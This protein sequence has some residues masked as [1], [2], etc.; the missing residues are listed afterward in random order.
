MMLKLQPF[1][2]T[3]KHVPGKYL[4]I[5]DTL[6]RDF[7]MASCDNQM[8]F[9]E[10]LE[11]QVAMLIENLPVTVENWKLISK[12]SSEDFLLTKLKQYILKGWPTNYKD[13]DEILRPFFEFKDELVVIKELIFR[14]DRILIPVALKKYMLNKLHTGHPGINRMVKKAELT[15][16][17]KGINQDIKKYVKS[18]KSCQKFQDNQIKQVMKYKKVPELSWAVVGCDIFELNQKYYI[19]VV[20]SLSNFIEIVSLGD[21][22][23]STVI[24]ELKTIFARHGIPLILYTDGA[25]C[26]D[27][28]LFRQFTKG[29]DFIH[30][31]SS[32]HY[33]KSNG[34]AE[35]A[36][37]SVK[38]LFKKAF[39]AGEDPYLALLNLRN[40]PRGNV[41][42]PASMLMGRNLRTNI[43]C[44]FKSLVPKITY[45]EDRKLLE[46]SKI[47]T[48]LYYDKT[49]KKETKLQVGEPV[50]FQKIPKATWTPGTVQA[51]GSTPRSYVIQGANG[52]VY[53]R[54][55]IHVTPR[56]SSHDITQTDWSVQRT[57]E[58]SDQTVA[59]TPAGDRKETVL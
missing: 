21:L 10:D 4:Y 11:M 56:E 39:D 19:V 20:D 53:N 25:L 12:Y 36:V 42:A 17:W 6:S 41:H 33:P 44:S 49:A 23:S 50:W 40:T 7:S 59:S 37:K 9:G 24:E 8:E 31:M 52:E 1:R 13:V 15:I 47:K 5:A 3:I 30:I 27:S 57:R 45:K 16:Y 18:C 32:P 43:P 35:S 58:A 22:K 34:L 46:Q 51:I 26:F 2:L 55:S 14:G 38:K 54:N 28:E 48:K 29:W